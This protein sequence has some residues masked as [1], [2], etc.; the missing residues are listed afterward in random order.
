[1]HW[2]SYEVF[3]VLSGVTLFICALLPR[4]RG[5]D[6]AWALLGAALFVGYGI[7]VANQSTG[8]WYFPVWIF[9]IPFAGGAYL[10]YRVVRAAAGKEPGR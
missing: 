9:V 6:R 3:S 1:M 4:M 7:Y 2:G 5:K 10:V 8:T